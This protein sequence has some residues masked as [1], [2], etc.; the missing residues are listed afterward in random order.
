MP[1]P[2]WRSYDKA[3]YLKDCRPLLF[4]WSTTYKFAS[5]T[6]SMTLDALPSSAKK[7]ETC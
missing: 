2:G 7:I 6:S 4:P 3:M 5:R 1:A